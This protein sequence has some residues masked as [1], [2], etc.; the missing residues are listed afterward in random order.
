MSVVASTV[1]AP[2][3]SAEQARAFLNILEDFGAER[4]RFQSTAKAVLN[5]LEDLAAEKARLEV[6][7]A[8]V[9]RSEQAIRQSLKEKE[10]LLQEVHHR[11]KNNLQMIWSLINMQVRQIHDD[12]ARSA[13]E[14]CQRRVQAI[15]LIHEQLY[16]SRNYARVPFSEYT[17]SLAANIFQATG[18]SPANVSLAIAVED[19]SLPVDKAIPCGLVLNELITNALK[20]AFPNGRK[21]TIRVELGKVPGNRLR[22][23][24][25]DDGVGLPA[26]FDSRT[27]VSLG[28]HLVRMLTKQVDGELEVRTDGRTSFCVTVP[29]TEE[30]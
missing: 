17:R 10:V 2:H 14:E 1:T 28:L 13:L 26:G 4:D 21:G 29:M 30:P 20:H 3:T 22:L 8:A 24:V 12:S 7:R 18:V 27:A 23:V 25:S 5:I 11:V 6:A 19:I 16:Q 15:A 9:V